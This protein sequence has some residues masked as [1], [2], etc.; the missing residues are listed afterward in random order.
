[1]WT[2]V[3]DTL[4]CTDE[5]FSFFEKYYWLDYFLVMLSGDE[6]FF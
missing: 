5:L 4:V 6:V 3:T 1:M 2:V